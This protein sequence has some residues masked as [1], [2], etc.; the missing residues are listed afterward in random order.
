[1]PEISGIMMHF[2]Y[3]GDDEIT[4]LVNFTTHSFYTQL[5]SLVEHPSNP[6]TGTIGVAQTPG[7]KWYAKIEFAD[8]AAKDGFITWIKANHAS[9]LESIRTDKARLPAGSTDWSE[10]LASV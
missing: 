7:G 10:Y 1:M 8:T 6:H 9:T 5:E 2:L 3:D 4:G